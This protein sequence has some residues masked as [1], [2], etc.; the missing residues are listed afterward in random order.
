MEKLLLQDES[1]ETRRQ[2]LKD[3]ADRVEQFT[4]MKRFTPEEIAEKKT[5]LSEEMIKLREIEN[6]FKEIKEAFKKRMDPLKKQV[7][8]LLT[9]INYKARNITE[10]CYVRLEY[11][12]N[13]AGY[14]NADG[15]LIYTRPLEIAEQQK[16]IMHAMRE[17]TNDN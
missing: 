16:T 15:E 5:V 8:V 11:S 3:S 13:I 1:Q 2:I 14:Y 9:D 12:E 6:E 10:E 17:G 7:D 4:Y